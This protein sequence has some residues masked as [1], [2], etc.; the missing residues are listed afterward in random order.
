[1]HA[2][3]QEAWMVFHNKIYECVVSTIV[4]FL[5]KV[6][7]H[8]IGFV[9][10][11]KRMLWFQTQR[12]P[13]LR[14]LNAQHSQFSCHLRHGHVRPSVRQ[15]W[16]F[17]IGWCQS[18]E[19]Q[20]NFVWVLLHHGWTKNRSAWVSRNRGMGGILYAVHHYGPVLWL[21][22]QHTTPATYL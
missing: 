3:T 21:G 11:S 6:S 12:R 7:H 1:M 5:L 19:T 14:F 16:W 17:Q 20:P 8:V 10:P 13:S 15:W 9:R 2:V 18:D 4:S 22:Q